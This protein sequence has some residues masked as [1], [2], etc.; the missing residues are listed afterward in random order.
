MNPVDHASLEFADVYGE[1]ALRAVKLAAHVNQLAKDYQGE[2]HLSKQRCED[3][4]VEASEA[5]QKREA[6]EKECADLR[7]KLKLADDQ[8]KVLENRSVRKDKAIEN[9]TTNWE[10]AEKKLEEAVRL[11]EAEI[12]AAV[13]GAKRDIT[14]RFYARVSKARKCFEEIDSEALVSMRDLYEMKSNLALLTMLQKPDAP[15]LDDEVKNVLGAIENV[16]EAGERFN[17]LWL[18]MD[19]V[20]T[21]DSTTDGLAASIGVSE[22]SGS[23]RG[24]PGITE[25]AAKERSGKSTPIEDLADPSVAKTGH[26]ALDFSGESMDEFVESVQ[27]DAAA[28]FQVMV[29]CDVNLGDEEKGTEEAGVGE[30]MKAADGAEAKMS[31]P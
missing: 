17:R 21:L 14:S 3:A 4:R 10:E 29:S 1:V 5:N 19:K 16:K 18:E 13:V 20:L 15:S 23:N 9:A 25:F 11:K 31:T 28:G 8:I 7:A 12:V 27:K 30:E 26:A 24:N 6:A 2:L 22:P